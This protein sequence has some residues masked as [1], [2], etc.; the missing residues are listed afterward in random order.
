MCKTTIPH[1]NMKSHCSKKK[2]RIENVKQKAQR[3]KGL[4]AGKY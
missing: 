2:G 4:I 3:I 1:H